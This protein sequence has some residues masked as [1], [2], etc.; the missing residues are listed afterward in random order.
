MAEHYQN[1]SF[2]TL[3][4]SPKDYHR[5]HAPLAGKLIS[6]TYVPGS[7]F[8]VNQITA[9]TIPDL[10]ARNERLVVHLQTEI[11][12]MAMVYVG[13]TIVASIETVWSGVVTPPAGPAIHSWSYEDKPI[14]FAKGEEMA[15]FK[16]GS[17]VILVAPENTINWHNELTAGSAVRMGSGLASFSK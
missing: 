5:I 3:Y 7:L 4:L 6:M 1:G 14:E 17:T 2:A 8:S 16:L 9:R 13:A 15:R 12:P 10:F 11:G